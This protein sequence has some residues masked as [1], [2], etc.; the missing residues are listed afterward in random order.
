MMHRIGA[1]AGLMMVGLACGGASTSGVAL[2]GP[3]G[4]AICH[5]TG[6]GTY[7]PFL[8]SA[9]GLVMDLN[10]HKGHLDDIIPIPG[11]GGDPAG[12]NMTPENILILNNGCVPP[13]GPG[14]PLETDA[15]VPAIS[16]GNGGGAAATTGSAAGRGYNVEGAVGSEAPSGSPIPAAAYLVVALAALLAWRRWGGAGVPGGRRRP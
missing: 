8:V 10:G 15:E 1:V 16:S 5:A 2:T 7:E 9:H 12:Q 6:A 14:L 3:G 4:V 11:F 13:G